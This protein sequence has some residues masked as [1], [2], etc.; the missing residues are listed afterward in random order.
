MKL[1]ESIKELRDYVNSFLISNCKNFDFISSL[2]GFNDELY[3]EEYKNHCF[4]LKITSNK[5]NLSVIEILFYNKN[6]SKNP[7]EYYLGSIDF[8]EV[9]FIENILEKINLEKIKNEQ[10]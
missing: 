6:N 8:L 5:N 2:C 10:I 1:F 3:C 7:Y 9:Q 4:E